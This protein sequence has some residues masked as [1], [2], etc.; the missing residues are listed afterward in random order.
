MLPAADVGIVVLTN[1]SPVGAAET[2]TTSFSDLVR[3]G[4][5]ER[6]WLGYYGPI[7]QTLF[8]NHSSVAEPAPASP[9]AGP[10]HRRLCRHLHQRLRR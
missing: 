10:A 4:T 2:V 5:I 1:A 6:D 3:T 8:V 9:A 7:F